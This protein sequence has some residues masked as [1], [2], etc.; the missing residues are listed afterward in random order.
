MVEKAADPACARRGGCGSCEGLGQATGLTWWSA[1]Y[2]RTRPGL[3][4]SLGERQRSVCEVPYARMVWDKGRR[5]MINHAE[6]RV[7]TALYLIYFDMMIRMV[8]FTLLPKRHLEMASSQ[9]GRWY[10]CTT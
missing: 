5:K 10:I 4:S 6:R 2:E 8:L 1:Q 7:R 9:L 3:R